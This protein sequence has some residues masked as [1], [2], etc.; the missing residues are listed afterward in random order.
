MR[1]LFLTG[2]KHKLAEAKAI[3][4]EHEVEGRALDLPEI[5]SLNP[6]EII[7]EKLA[8]ARREVKEQDVTI[9]VEDVS[10]WI[11]STGLPGP[12]IRFFNETIGRE[13]LV[14][15]ARAF[16]DETARAECNVGILVPG[17][18]E[19]EFFT[20]TVTGRV[21]EPRG[22]SGFGFDPVFEPNGQPTG[23]ERTYAEM[24]VEGKNANSHRR[25]ALELIRER[26]GK[27]N[28]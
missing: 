19:P 7:R 8:A 25:M 9:M 6:E 2:N 17:E 16:G 1:I 26:L 22:E 27:S 21:V 28:F 15:F 24:D 10:F 23:E 12:F 20:G 4:D 13:G 3:L 5:Q 14:A 11:G 18:E